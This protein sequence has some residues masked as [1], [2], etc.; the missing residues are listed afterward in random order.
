MR[1]WLTIILTAILIGSCG[2]SVFAADISDKAEIPVNAK[3]EYNMEGEYSADLEDGG[4]AVTVGGDIIITVTNAPEGAVQL[5]VT[6]IPASEKAAWSWIT[7]CFKGKGTP[8]HTFDIYF[9]D[10]NGS[11]INACGAVVTIDCPHCSSKPMVCSLTT[12]GAV[13]ELRDHTRSVS[14]TFTT[15]GSH[16]YVMAE[17]ASASVSTPDANDDQKA[18]EKKPTDSK[19]DIGNTNKK[20]STGDHAPLGMWITAAAVSAAGTCVLNFFCFKRKKFS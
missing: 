8:I 10:E 16:Y 19:A 20:P 14:V 7:D 12:D 3:A 4:A 11:R 2:A 6:P 18:D 5:I 13:N 17:K 9:A 1:K 15:D